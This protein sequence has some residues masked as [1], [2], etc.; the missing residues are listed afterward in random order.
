MEHP[1]TENQWREVLKQYFPGSFDEKSDFLTR[2]ESKLILNWLQDSPQNPLNRTQAN[3]ILHLCHEA[4]VSEGFFNYYFL[5]V[6]S[7]HPYPANRVIDGPMPS[8]NQ[9]AIWS[10]EQLDWGF[11]RFFTDALLYWGNIRSAYQELRNKDYAEIE[12]FYS[13]KRYNIEQMQ[14]R[15]EPFPLENIPD[16][17]RYLISET[18]CKAYGT[19]EEKLIPQIKAKLL[20]LAQAGSWPTTVRQLLSEGGSRLD[21]QTEF[22]LKLGATDLMDVNVQDQGELEAR[23]DEVVGRFRGARKAGIV[24]THRYLS[25]VSEMDV[26]VATSMREKQQFLDV[27]SSCREIFD[28]NALKKLNLR[29]FDPTMSAAGGHEDKGLIECLMVKCAKASLYFAGESDSFGKD[30]EVAM[31]MSLGKPVVILCPDTEKGKERERIF[32]DIHPLSKLIDF[33]SGVVNGAMITRNKDIA[34]ELLGRIFENRMEYD[35]EQ[36]KGYFRLKER[37]TGSVVRLQTSDRLLRETFWNYYHG[38]S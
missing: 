10:S 23:I 16:D 1:V 37:L 19:D 20:E 3:Q 26:Y 28:Q 34:R 35:F 38:I 5:T 13:K 18:A 24:N 6:P 22:L 7:K 9:S 4:G 31:T 14:S 25:L 33:N 36:T 11:R 8:L 27:A 21:R 32:R 17:D 29:Y 2:P 15:G 30:A 12:S